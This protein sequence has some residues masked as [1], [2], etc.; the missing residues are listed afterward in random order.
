VQLPSGVHDALLTQHG[1]EHD[2]QV[3]IE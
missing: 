1:I 2:E 3:Q